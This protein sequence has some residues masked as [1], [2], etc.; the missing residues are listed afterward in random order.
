MRKGQQVW[1]IGEWNPAGGNYAF[2]PAEVVEVNPT[3]SCLTV[4]LGNLHETR[5]VSASNLFETP[6]AARAAWSKITY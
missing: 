2:A 1:W 6:E 4:R 3:L 5:V